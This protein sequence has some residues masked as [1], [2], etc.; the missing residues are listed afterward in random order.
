M[1]EPQVSIVITTH[2]EAAGIG[3]TLKTVA[4]QA[5]APAFEVV[6]VDDRSTDET[7]AVAREAGLDGLRILHSAPDPA[8]PLT[9]RQQALDL[10][11]R[12]ARGTVIVT[13][14]GDS[15]VPQRWLA[16]MVAPI[17]GGEARAVAGPITFAPPDSAVALWQIADAAYYWQ[18]AGLLARFGGGGVFF[19]NFAFAADLYKETGGFA[20]IGGALT[21]DLAFARAIQERGHRIAFRKGDGPVE[22]AP[23]PD[24]PAL[25]DRTLRISQGPPSLLSAVL[26][27]WPLTLLATALAAP[28]GGAFFWLFLAR[29]A[30]GAVFV[31]L[32]IARAGAVARGLNWASYEPLAFALAARVLPR[33]VTGA[34]PE[35]GGRRYDR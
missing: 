20:A 23:C 27:V 35:W 22:V 24:V 8:S 5:G 21:E 18:V 1:A 13:L 6:L 12:E 7:V 9:T 11:F 4:A 14:D 19:G 10:G 32:A 17:L 2:N 31:R 30:L 16:G 33:V 26:T 3:A 34:A 15:R 25:V 29:Y 28:F